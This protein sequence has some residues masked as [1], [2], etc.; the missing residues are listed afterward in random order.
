MSNKLLFNFIGPQGRCSCKGMFHFVHHFYIGAAGLISISGLL[1]VPRSKGNHL[2]LPICGLHQK[3]IHIPFLGL[4][5]W[6]D[7]LVVNLPGFVQLVRLNLDLN[8]SYL[9][10]CS[11]L[12]VSSLTV[13]RYQVITFSAFI[14][15]HLEFLLR[16]AVRLILF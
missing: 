11:L 3:H 14:L 15:Q 10:D 5:R 12:S 9:H 8:K 2:T 16:P 6:H 13:L 1:A 7:L 4:H